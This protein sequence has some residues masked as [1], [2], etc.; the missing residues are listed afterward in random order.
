[1]QVAVPLASPGQAEQL[2]PQLAGELLARHWPAQRWYPALQVSPH[3]VPSQVEAPFASE[4][5]LL[6]LVPQESVEVL[7]RHCAPQAWKPE[8]H[9]HCLV[10]GS[11]RWCAP[12]CAS[13]VQPEGPASTA[14][15][16]PWTHDAA[17]AHA[18]QDEPPDPQAA[19]AVP[20]MHVE[21]ASQQPEQ[22]AAEHV[23]T[24]GAVPAPQASMAESANRA[25][26]RFRPD[27][28]ADRRC[29]PRRDV[30]HI[31]HHS[32]LATRGPTFA[33]APFLFRIAPHPCSRPGRRLVPGRDAARYLLKM[34]PNCSTAVPSGPSTG[35]CA[36][37][38]M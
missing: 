33:A 11:Q 34:N 30:P 16:W 10:A 5:H 26:A 35:P 9:E 38:S 25:I 14:W 4:G 19:C 6:Q 13:L 7:A 3:F 21:V 29:P 24:T 2:A 23:T 37:P 8:T 22:L 17:P 27:V 31:T 32:T 36:C 12:H 20:A 15:H 1:M 28:P 18:E